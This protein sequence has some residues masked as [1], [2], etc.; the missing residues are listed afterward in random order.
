MR[1]LDYNRDT[2]EV[3]KLCERGFQDSAD[4]SELVSGIISSIRKRGDE[5]LFEFTEK[6][7][8]FSL[9]AGSLP[10]SEGEINAAFSR[11]SSEVVDALSIARENIESYHSR[12]L[13]SFSLG[14]EFDVKEGITVGEKI[15]PIESVGCYVPG[16]RASYPSSVLMNVVPALVAGV[17]RVVVVSPPPI[18]DAVLAACKICGV[19]EVY[20]VGGAQAVAALAYGTESIIPV[21][22]IVGPGNKYVAEAKRQVYGKVDIDT[23]AGPS[24]ILV[25]ADES[26]NPDYIKADLLAQAEHD[27]DA[28]C[29]LVTTDKNIV[30]KIGV[31]GTQ[32]TAVRVES[33]EDAIKFTNQYA[34]EHLEVMCEDAEQVADR[35]MYA[36]AIFIGDYSP[37]AAGDYASGANHV[38]PTG[39]AARYASPLSVRDFLKA[40]SVQKLSRKGLG[41]LSDVIT[42]LSGV[43]GLVGH[44]GS[45]KV[46]VY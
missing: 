7:D 10:V 19:K 3:K 35:I 43:E 37:V 38:L 2:K 27:P 46:R 30:E 1:V 25:I 18:S 45:V 6:F 34:P 8:G 23:P 41:E 31:E 12:Q 5:A 21:A 44:G 24:E 13:D 17:K 36:G 28:L 32:Y 14:W 29:I 11:V 9:D 42:V 20:G 4:V 33:I 39:G 15:S 16:G 22:K 26:S 40:S